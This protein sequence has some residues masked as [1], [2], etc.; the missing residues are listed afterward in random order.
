MS[1]RGDASHPT[2]GKDPRRLEPERTLDPDILRASMA[3]QRAAL[4]T[5]PTPYVLISTQ[6]DVV[7]LNNMFTEVTG[8]TLADLPDI[9]ACMIKMRRV[10]E[11]AVETML[12][13]WLRQQ[14]RASV[15]EV[16]VVT[17]WNEMRI[18][19]IRTTDPVLWPDGRTV[20]LQS[21]IDLTEQRRLEEALR[22]N[23]EEMRVRLAELEALY[24]SAPLGL[25]MLDK[26]LRFIRA[27]EALAT[28]NGMP[29]A[30]HIGRFVFDIVPHR[31]RDAEPV[32]RRVLETGKPIR[33]FESHG[34]AGGKPGVQRDWLEHIYPLNDAKGEA[35]GLGV[36]VEEITERKK[37][38]S[39][40]ASTNAAL[41]RTLDLL[42]LALRTAGVS[43]FTQDKDLRYIWVGGDYFGCDAD[44]AV[45]KDDAALLPPE[46]V[47]PMLALK[48]RVFATGE[49]ASEDMPYHRDGKTHWC[50]IHV[51]PWRSRQGVVRSLLGAVSDVTGRKATEQHIRTL[52]SELAHRSKNLLTVIQ[53][54]AR[55]SVSPNVPSTVFVD[56]FI[57]RLSGLAQ[58]HDLLARED[59]RGISMHELVTSQIGH[60]KTGSAERLLIEGPDMIL[61]PVAAQNL[62]MA[63]HELSTNAVKY[64]ALSVAGGHVRI[65]WSLFKDQDEQ[66]RMQLSWVER[67]GPP[68]V[69]PKRRGFGRFVIEAIAA[70]ALSGTVDLRF[71]PEGVTCNIEGAADDSVLASVGLNAA[72]RAGAPATS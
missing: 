69:E 71:E 41:R 43:V 31:Q 66:D 61:T 18:W 12:D 62:G 35:V 15:K 2:I 19:Q 3:S 55:R 22:R 29:T 5:A 16:T 17:A 68:V 45:G 50:N 63:I 25:A 1:D 54:M 11:D 53:V 23:Q 48:Q 52:L 51:E 57:E 40:L 36:I 67:G 6:G 26:D 34:D 70:R 56:S 33:N 39:E 30:D 49:A 14:S 47:A 9:R 7:L 38:E 46:L 44:A 13:G 21:M 8:Y 37:V 59:W 4:M 58:S 42:F 64:G 60:L 20:I 32:M 27:N 24:S 10:P 72:G 28:I 65:S